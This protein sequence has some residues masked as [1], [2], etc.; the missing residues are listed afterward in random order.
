MKIFIVG[1][2]TDV[3]KTYYGKMLMKMGENVIKPIETGLNTFNDINDSDSYSYSL[4]QNKNIREINCCFFSEPVSPHYASK[5]DNEEIDI[6]KI[7]AFI[8]R[9][10]DVT[11]ELAGGLMVPLKDC[12]TQLDL[13]K[14]TSNAC[15]ELV[16]A[17]KLG[18]INHALLSLYTLKKENIHVSVIVFNNLGKESTSAMINNIETIKKF[19]DKEI[20]IKVI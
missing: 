5:I 8:N 16:I 7:K 18:C 1:T 17:N 3:G 6:D 2:D 15:V 12:Y 10:E 19:V 11:I 4:G 20:V 13:I 14:E 9:L